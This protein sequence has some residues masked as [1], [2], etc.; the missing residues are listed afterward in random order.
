M[1]AARNH[2]S[3]EHHW[4]CRPRVVAASRLAL[5]EPVFPMCTIRQVWCDFSSL[6]FCD[7]IAIFQERKG[8]PIFL[9]LYHPDALFISCPVSELRDISTGP[10]APFWLGPGNFL[11]IS[12]GGKHSVQSKGKEAAALNQGSRTC[13]LSLQVTPRVPMP[14]HMP[15]LRFTPNSPHHALSTQTL[16]SDF[17]IQCSTMRLWAASSPRSGVWEAWLLGDAPGHFWVLLCSLEAASPWVH[18][19]FLPLGIGESSH[20]FST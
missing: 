2:L 5:S 18:T 8:D 1:G 12:Y 11:W 10:S 4:E 20:L 17:L 15:M 7:L 19:R 14:E 13:S 16:P 9:K 3:R 6:T